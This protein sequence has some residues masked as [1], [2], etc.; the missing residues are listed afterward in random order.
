MD[1]KIEVKK[2]KKNSS[3]VKNWTRYQTYRHRDI[4]K[5][6]FRLVVIPR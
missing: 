4:L 1:D 5:D 6:N 2:K 3:K